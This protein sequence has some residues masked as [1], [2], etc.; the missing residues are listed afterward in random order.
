VEEAPALRTR[1]TVPPVRVDRQAAVPARR[2]VLA[3][4]AQ[5][6]EARL[7]RVAE[8][9]E[10]PDPAP[11]VRDPAMEARPDLAAQERLAEARWTAA[12]FAT[13]PM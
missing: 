8:A 9:R 11:L 7:D 2:A 4:P 13:I 5:A 10:A 6:A 12:P 1:E 3:G